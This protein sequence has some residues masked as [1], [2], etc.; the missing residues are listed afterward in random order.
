MYSIAEWIDGCEYSIEIITIT[1]KE[2]IA[3]TKFFGNKYTTAEKINLTKDDYKI[4][5]HN[6]YY[7]LQSL[8]DCHSFCD[9]NRYVTSRE[10]WL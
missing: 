4:S 3:E 9:K 2:N 10:W 7:I 5:R 1:L 8:D 6:K